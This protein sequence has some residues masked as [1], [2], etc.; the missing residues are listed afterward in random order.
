M[1]ASR[2][3]RPHRHALAGLLLTTVALSACKPK[4]QAA[5]PPPPPTTVAAA[6]TST[7]TTTTTMPAPPPAWRT[8][9]WGMK[10]AEVLAAFP[11][12][13][14]KLAQPVDF[15]QPRPGPSDIGIPAYEADGSTFRVLFGVGP[16]GLGRIQLTALKPSSAACEDIEKR[17]TDENGKPASRGDVGGSL[18]GQEIV[19]TTPVARIALACA[20]KLSLNFR[21]VTLEYTPPASRAN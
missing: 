12:E 21:T 18:P 16:E 13:A 17:L 20:E 6:T 19:W 10:K 9:R 14:Q 7:T 4:E 2:T 1:I 8:A 3:R 15:G 5:T 11:G